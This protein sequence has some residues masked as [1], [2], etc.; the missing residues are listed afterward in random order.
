MAYKG[1]YCHLLNSEVSFDMSS[2]EKSVFETV[3]L[4]Y[5]SV[6]Q[7]YGLSL[8]RDHSL[9]EDS[10][11]ELFIYIYE[12]DIDLENITNIKAYL[13]ISL[14]RRILSKKQFFSISISDITE[15][16]ESIEDPK[17]ENNRIQVL[18]S[19]LPTRQREAIYLKFFNKLSAKE[20]AEVMEIKPQVVANTLFKALKKLK[21]IASKI[22][23][24]LLI[25]GY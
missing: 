24:L 25:G 13:F 9:V 23:I 17:D 11:Q 10:I 12:K 16:H 8:V 6:L 2:K 22:S 7:S 15:D 14:R 1:T 19:A 4:Q 21:S 18:L 3:F 20:I 5:H